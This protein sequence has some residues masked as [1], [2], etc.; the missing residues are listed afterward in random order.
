MP[1]C[2]PLT[3]FYFI[4]FYFLGF[5]RATSTAYGSS[6]ARVQSELHLLAYATATAMPA[7]SV[8]FSTAHGNAGS[9]THSV[10]PGMEPS[11]S[12]V[13]VGFITTVPWWE[14]L[15]L[16]LGGSANKVERLQGERQTNRQI[17]RTKGSVTK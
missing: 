4:L 8:T 2:L 7:M 17:G 10:R 15:H 12:Y 14:L 13:L 3:L 1:W 9:L 6:Q 11:S 5:F 16:T